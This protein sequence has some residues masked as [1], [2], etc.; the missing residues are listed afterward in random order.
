MRRIREDPNAS[1]VTRSVRSGVL[2][3]ES[4]SATSSATGD[5]VTTRACVATSS[6]GTSTS[7]VV[8]TVAGV[9]SRRTSAVAR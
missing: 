9:G 1:T 5:E 8:A 3:R 2:D 6:G 7:P 4:S